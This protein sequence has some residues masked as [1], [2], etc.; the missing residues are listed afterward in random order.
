MHV[1]SSDREQNVQY[2][3][4]LSVIL[5]LILVLI[6]IFS[7]FGRDATPPLAALFA[8]TKTRLF[9]EGKWEKSQFEVFK[10]YVKNLSLHGLQ[11]STSPPLL[12]IQFG[13]NPRFWFCSTSLV[14]SPPFR[15]LKRTL[16][17]IIC[18]KKMKI[19]CWHKIK[20]QIQHQ[21]FFGNSS[22]FISNCMA[23]VFNLISGCQISGL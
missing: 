23:V 11:F 16:V 18:A 4:R 21:K 19:L 15:I 9:G 10:I 8:P 22:K 20:F 14:S 5:F 2:W 7:R 17:S 13:Y 6:S 3:F 12:K 1:S